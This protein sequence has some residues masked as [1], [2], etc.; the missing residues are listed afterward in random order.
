MSSRSATALEVCGWISTIG[1]VNQRMKIDVVHAEIDHH[2]DI[3]HARRKR[4]D[5]GDGDRE[6][7]LILDRPLDRL[8][9]WVEALDMSHHER[10]ASVVSRRYN[11]AAFLD[12]RGDRL[13]HQNMDALGDA[14]ERDVMMQMG[15]RRDD[16]RIGPLAEQ[17][18]DILEGGAI[19]R[20]G[21]KIPLGVV[22]I[23]YA[24]EFHA[25]HVREHSRMVATH[26]ADA[27]D[28]DPQFISPHHVETLT[29]TP[30]GAINPGY[31][32]STP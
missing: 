14:L 23:G 7:V 32:P 6:D 10:D 19:E 21:D 8:H 2:A 17:C 9:R 12:R 29:P 25:G 20:V 26:D 3:R 18:V 27:Y 30:T 16:D 5:P 31:S 13:L 4:S 1:S 24:D 22:W 15:R 11:V 28:P